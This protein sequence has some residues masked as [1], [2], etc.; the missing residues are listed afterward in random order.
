MN[1]CSMYVPAWVHSALVSFT[2]YYTFIVAF[3]TTYSEFI[4]NT[5][6]YTINLHNFIIV[7]SVLFLYHV[8]WYLLL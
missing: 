4:Y 8:I 5:T 2:Y 7:F 6:F 1:V 3:I